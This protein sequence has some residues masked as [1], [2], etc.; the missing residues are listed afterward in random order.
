ALVMLD[1]NRWPIVRQN[2]EAIRRAVADFEPAGLITVAFERSLGRP[3]GRYPAR[4][5]GPPA[6]GRDRAGRHPGAGLD[7]SRG[8][9]PEARPGNQPGHADGPHSWQRR[10]LGWVGPRDGGK[11]RRWPRPPARRLDEARAVAVTLGP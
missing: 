6:S 11:P 7:R 5:P 2:L 4:F 1:T 9:R 10:T 3:S 8:Q